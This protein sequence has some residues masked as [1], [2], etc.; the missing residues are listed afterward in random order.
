MRK[1]RP[2][3]FYR[4]YK[5]KPYKAIGIVRHSETLEEMALYESLYPNDLGRMWVR[6]L[7]MFLEDVE[8]EGVLR[9]RFADD[10]G[11]TPDE[12]AKLKLAEERE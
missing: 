8:I 5:N 2:G 12:V 7:A 1:L 6:P 9:P 10:N 11:P 4:H 3:G